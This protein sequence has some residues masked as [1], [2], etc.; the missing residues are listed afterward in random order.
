MDVKTALAILQD[1]LDRCRREDMR[2]A[3]VDAALNFLE[4]RASRKWPF[5]QFRESLDQYNTDPL[6]EE[7]RWQQVNASLN[8]VPLAV[9]GKS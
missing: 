2:T 5:K 1:A 6:K 7:G 3:E 4:Q 8:A 9:G